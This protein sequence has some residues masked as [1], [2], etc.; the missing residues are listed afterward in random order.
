MSGRIE[1]RHVSQ[2]VNG[3]QGESD[4]RSRAYWRA[5]LRLT[6]VLLLV[7]AAGKVKK[8]DDSATEKP[9]ADRLIN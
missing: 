4:A 5:T 9:L 7:W 1:E 2:N 3:S 8:S 6:T